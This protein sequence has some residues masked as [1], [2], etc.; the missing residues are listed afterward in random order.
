LVLLPWVH[1][2]GRSLDAR[3][4]TK[5]SPTYPNPSLSTLRNVIVPLVAG[6]HGS[7]HS[8]ALRT[9][10]FLAIVAAM[11]IAAS[12]LIRAGREN[13]RARIAI[14]CFIAIPAALM[15][16]HAM[17]HAIGP[18]IFAE[19]YLL[20][21]IPLFAALLAAGVSLLRWRLAMPVAATALVALGIAVF[22]QRSGRQLEPDPR[23]FAT[24]VRAAN[25]QC[26][27]T[28]S[29]VVAF[30]FRHDHA[31]VDRPFGLQVGGGGVRIPATSVVG[32]RGRNAA[33][34]H[35]SEPVVAAIDDLRVAG[36]ARPGI[37]LRERH[38]PF[39][40]LIERQLR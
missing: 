3:G 11:G 29:A 26:L 31:I 12:L 39:V 36:G 6:E 2:I 8:L 1:Q 38:G 13:S 35:R 22:I 5:V 9:I 15:I 14:W 34:A 10:E 20:T 28:N 4:V 19:R 17:I 21:E 33:P 23:V 25:P 40:L 16:L 18:N 7:A 30:Y 24:Q 27:L 37:G 32:C